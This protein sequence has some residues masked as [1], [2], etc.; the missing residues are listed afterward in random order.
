VLA[1]NGDR[2]GPEPPDGAA[3][4]AEVDHRV[5]FQ[6]AARHA[7]DAKSAESFSTSCPVTK[8]AMMQRV[9][10][11]IGESAP[12]HRP[13]PDHSASAPADCRHH[14]IGVVAM[15]EIGLDQCGSGRDPRGPPS[16]H[17]AHQRVAGVAVV[18]GADL[19]RWRFAS[20]H[21]VLALFHRH[22]HRLFAEHVKARLEKA[23]VIS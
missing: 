19:C 7:G 15:A 5:V 4:H 2:R 12:R 17:V 10:A 9:D 16:P 3:V 1:A 8:L 11:A 21:D 23:L 22:G 18:D 20:A 14:R 13:A 6:L